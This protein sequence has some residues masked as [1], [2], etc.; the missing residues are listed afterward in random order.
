[1]YFTAKQIEE[2]L[3]IK[4][5]ARKE[6]R[7]MK[8][9]ISEQGGDKVKEAFL[10]IFRALRL[11]A[12]DI[13][14]SLRL[15]LGM[16]F[17]FDPEKIEKKINDFD[18]RR[19]KINAE[20][21][22]IVDRA[23]E[24]IGSADPILTMAVIGPANFFAMQ[25]IGAG[26]TAGKTVAEVLTATNWDSIID[27]FTVT[28][29]VNQSLQQFF[30]EYNRNEQ[31]RIERDSEEAVGPGGSGK[32]Q[33]VMGKLANLFSEGADTAGIPLNEQV[34][35]KG[36]PKM[37]EKEAIYMFIKATGLDEK[38]KKLLDDHKK[39]LKEALPFLQSEIEPKVA[40]SNMFAANDINSFRSAAEQAK[41]QNPKIKDEP[42]KQFEQK[43]TEK[44]QE[45][46]KN[47]KIMD[48][49][50]K[51]FGGN[52]PTPEQLNK[53]VSDKV[54]VGLKADFDKQLANELKKVI[55][56][57][58]SSLAKLKI[59]QT[60]LKYMRESSDSEVK[61][62]ADIYEKLL[63]SYNAINKDYESKAKSKV[64]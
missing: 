62:L 5:I 10:D 31:K 6:I 38:F 52:L 33:S 60:T 48:D 63:A 29:D 8:S 7:Q 50:K 42:F 20:W 2:Q 21:A 37:S 51:G 32:K 3:R 4:R 45:M 1:M 53:V 14:N 30:Q 58:K 19:Q 24:A 27:S 22:P 59:D 34:E 47:S 18:T 57:T 16:L 44:T 41:R 12:M 40:L 43:M 28:L 56:S 25:G 64:A 46:L 55:D 11:A 15:A 61:E 17:T 49:V 36:P 35:Q 39:N 23:K 54:F 26:L 9:V 13:G